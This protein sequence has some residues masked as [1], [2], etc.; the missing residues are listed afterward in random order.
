MTKENQPLVS[1]IVPCYN[2]GR[3]LSQALDSVQKQTY[4]NWECIIINDGSTDN[5]EAIAKRYVQQDDRYQYIS[6]KN[7]GIA[8]TRNN[9]I[10]VAK[11]DYIQFLDADDLLQEQKI[12]L[13]VAYMQDHTAIDIVYG[14]ALFFKTDE[15]GIFLL[16]RSESKKANKSRKTSGEGHE[17]TRTIARDNFIEISAPLLRRTVFIKAGN[18]DAAYKSYEDWHFWFKCALAG[19]RFKYLPADGTLTYIRFGHSSLMTDKKQLTKS[20]IQFRRYMQQMLTGHS[21]RYNAYRIMKLY[22][23]N[24]LT[25]SK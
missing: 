15:P 8:A 14:D 7:Q 1:I 9:A 4:S 25:G 10:K 24:I 20:G 13:Q 19:M 21:K 11:G 2:Y 17:M 23:K 3:F 16:G 6:Q 18:F 12:A 5:T 22:I